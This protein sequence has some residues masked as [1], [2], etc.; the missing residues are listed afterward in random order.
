MTRSFLAALTLVLAPIVEEIFFRGWLQSA[1]EDDLA[2][3]RRWL[4]PLLSAFAFAAARPPLSF[5]PMLVLGLVCGAI[6]ARS[7]SV[8]PC[9]LA[10]AAYFGVSFGSRYLLNAP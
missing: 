10:H 6:Y 9:V 7:R 8:A 4:A 1:I 5:A 2:A 3:S